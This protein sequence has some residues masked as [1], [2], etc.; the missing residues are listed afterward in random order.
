MEAASND[1]LET[2]RLLLESGAEVNAKN[3]QGET[4]WDLTTD[5]EVEELL[6]GYGAIVPPDDDETVPETP[7]PSAAT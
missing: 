7:P 2:V 5:D 3:K 1:D 6:V 4:A